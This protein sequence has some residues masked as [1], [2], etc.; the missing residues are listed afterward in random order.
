MAGCCKQIP[1]GLVRSTGGQR[2]LFR[3]RSV[4]EVLDVC[5]LGLSS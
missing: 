5:P 3:P 4:W 2:G 1:G